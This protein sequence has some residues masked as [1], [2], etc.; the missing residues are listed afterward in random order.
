MDSFAES[1]QDGLLGCLSQP[2]SS[3]GRSYQDT[4]ASW[5]IALFADDKSVLAAP[6]VF[7]KQRLFSDLSEDDGA[8][9]QDKPTLLLV[10]KCLTFPTNL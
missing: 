3:T 1:L 8:S 10:R 7:S 4:V 2:T 5:I 6:K 9:E